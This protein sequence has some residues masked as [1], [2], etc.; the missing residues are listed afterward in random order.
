M[1]R[2]ISLDGYLRD[3]YIMPGGFA[4]KGKANLIIIMRCLG[5]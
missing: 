5:I 3:I 1:T 4:N 2:K